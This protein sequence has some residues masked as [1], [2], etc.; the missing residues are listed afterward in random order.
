M[1]RDGEDEWGRTGVSTK[2]GHSEAVSGRV[3]FVSSRFCSEVVSNVTGIV[4]LPTMALVSRL[5]RALVRILR[6]RREIQ[7]VVLKSIATMSAERPD[8]RA[9]ASL[10]LLRR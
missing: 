5:G 7:F 1:K 3:G 2:S 9:T 10:E 4:K 8:M 6:N